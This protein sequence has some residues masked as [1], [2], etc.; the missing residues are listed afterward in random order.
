MQ[1]VSGGFTSRDGILWITTWMGDVYRVDPFHSTIPHFATESVVHAIQE[2]APGVLWVGTLGKGLIRVDRSTGSMKQFATGSKSRYSL[3]DTW[4]TAIYD[5]DDSTLWIGSRNHLNRY[6]KKT[7]IFTQYENDPSDKTS[8]SKGWIAAIEAD[9]PGSLWIA[10]EEGL[11]HLDIKTEKFTHHRNDPKDSNSLSHNFVTTLL[12]GRS[13]NLWVGT[14]SG[15]LNLFD[16][17]SKKFKRFACGVDIGSIVEDSDNIVWVGTSDGLYRSNPAVDTFS[18]FTDPGF[19]MTSNTMITGI[20][21]DNQ[22]N[23]WVGSSEGI[24][25]F[26]RKRSEITVYNKNQGVDA[27]ALSSILMRGKKGI[28]GELFFGDRTGYYTFFPDQLKNNSTAPQIV[29]SDFRLA[30]QPVKPGQGSPLSQAISQTK[31]ISLNYDQNVFSFDFAGIHYGSPEDNQHL[32][33]LENLENRWRKAGT[34]KKAYYYNVPPGRYIFRVKAANSYGVW[35]EKDITVIIDPP[36]TAHGGHTCYIYWVL[37]PSY[38][39]LHGTVPGG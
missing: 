5:S 26:N 11:D 37:L 6:N 2:D 33:I 15:M 32:F 19:V 24:F 17:Q 7:Q 36:G 18:L 13:G 27:S 31:V 9:Q 28:R 1:A 30:D 21:E 23:L 29:I 16:P 22:K 20:V 38:G 34:E 39:S 25:R 14:N 8:L 3:S 10:T 35:A 12:N 4:I